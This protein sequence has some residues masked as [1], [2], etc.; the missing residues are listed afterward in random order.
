MERTVEEIKKEMTFAFVA[1]PDIVEEYGLDPQKTFEEQFSKVSIESIIFNNVAF[2]AHTN[3]QIFDTDRQKI[4]D[5]VDSMRPHT[6]RWYYNKILAFQYGRALTP[7]TDIYDEI[8]ESEKIVKYC[9]VRDRDGFLYIKVAKQLGDSPTP[10]ITAE[11]IALGEYIDQ[12]RDAGVHYEL[13]SY[14]AD[15]IK[16]KILIHYDPLVLRK[17]GTKISDNS[18]P[19]V[20]AVKG[21][22]K[23][24]RFD[25]MS[26]TTRQIA[27]SLIYNLLAIFIL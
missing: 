10:L 6:L 25:G 9:S 14:P 11:Q 20:E 15:N 3:E 19:V 18:Y 21:Y 17:D 4:I 2:C 16:L 27:N 12:I 26:S 7:E 1:S 23:K 24:L 13:V 22:I 5:Y 8:V